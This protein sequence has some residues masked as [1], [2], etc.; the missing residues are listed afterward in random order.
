[1]KRLHALFATNRSIHR[2]AAGFLIVGMLATQVTASPV[3]R[4]KFKPGAT[5]V[6]VVGR[7]RGNNDI[8]HYVLRVRANQHMH[9]SLKSTQLSN[10][11]L[12]VIFP[13]G[14]HVGRDMSGM[15][16]FDT[17]A[18]QAGD[19]RIDVFVGREGRNGGNPNGSFVLSITVE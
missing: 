7:L 6:A 13:S 4:I 1:M 8:V 5:K 10:P 14:E 9:I 3:I 19:Y 11:Q 17:D 18:T 2:L 15:A 12:D 16:P